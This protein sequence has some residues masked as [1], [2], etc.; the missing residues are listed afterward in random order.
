MT[1]RRAAR[2]LWLAGLRRSE[3]LGSLFFARETAV[4]LQFSVSLMATAL[5]GGILGWPCLFTP[6]VTT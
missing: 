3:V 4:D 1:I 5:D 6:A 2:E